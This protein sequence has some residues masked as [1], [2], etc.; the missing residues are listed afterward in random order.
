MNYIEEQKRFERAKEYGVEFSYNE[1]QNCLK[2]NDLYLFF[3]QEKAYL[4]ADLPVNEGFFDI[5]WKDFVPQTTS[6]WIH[7]S[8]DV[9]SGILDVIPTGVTQVIS[10]VLDIIH[11]LAYFVEAQYDTKN[12]TALYIGGAITLA[13]ASIPGAG[14]IGGLVAKSAVKGGKSIFKLLANFLPIP[15]AAKIFRKLLNFGKVGKA[16]NSTLLKNTDKWWMKGLSKLP[17]V[18]KILKTSP[19]YVDY[20]AKNASKYL[21]KDINLA[22]KA[23]G[24]H[25]TKNV[26]KSYK[27]LPKDIKKFIPEKEYAAILRKNADELLPSFDK[28]KA[29]PDKYLKTFGADNIPTLN[30]QLESKVINKVNFKKKLA[31]DAFNSKFSNPIVRAWYKRSFQRKAGKQIAN[32]LKLGKKFN[33][34]K[35]LDNMVKTTPSSVIARFAK[36]GVKKGIPVALKQKINSY[37]REPEIVAPITGGIAPID[38]DTDNTQADPNE[39]QKQTV[40][41]DKPVDVT[42]MDKFN[43]KKSHIESLSEMGESKIVFETPDK[44][45]EDGKLYMSGGVYDTFDFTT[46]MS[47]YTNEEELFDDLVKI[48]KKNAGKKRKTVRKGELKKWEKTPM[49]STPYITELDNQRYNLILWSEKDL[50]YH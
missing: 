3:D 7:F 50:K 30:K 27:K 23:M 6:D 29:N 49:V 35:M 44:K 41:R 15:I 39:V 31:E 14:N 1:K 26:S 48:G 45:G 46:S 19:K 42:L 33:Y 47:L 37:L 43:L 8:V 10:L 17:V 18:D 12:T 11:G 16:V 32:E 34:N 21:T 40:R 22:R 25:L 24:E 13:A 2:I 5:S 38:T 4:E 28:I 36:Q 20:F 9:I